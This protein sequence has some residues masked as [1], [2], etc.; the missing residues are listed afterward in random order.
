LIDRQQEKEKKYEKIRKKE[1]F[2][3]KCLIGEETR[4]MLKDRVPWNEEG[5][6]LFFFWKFTSHP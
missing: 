1:K 5:K 2:S 3:N 4:K 6:L